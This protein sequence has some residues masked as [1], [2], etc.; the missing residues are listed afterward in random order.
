MPPARR[1]INF[2]SAAAHQGRFGFQGWRAG[3]RV[4]RVPA[5]ASWPGWRQCPARCPGEVTRAKCSTGEWPPGW[6]GAGAGPCLAWAPACGIRGSPGWAGAGAGPCLAWAPASMWGFRAI[7]R[8]GRCGSR[9]LPGV[10]TGLVG[11]SGPRAG[12]AAGKRAV[13]LAEPRPVMPHRGCEL[14][15]I[16]RA[17]STLEWG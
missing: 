3:S 12:Q 1:S 8:L 4:R 2:F 17:G 14:A 11:F 10:G 7:L 9:A 5:R 15:G 16:R 6:A 13:T